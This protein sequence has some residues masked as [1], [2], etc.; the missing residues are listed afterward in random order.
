MVK[1]VYI[2]CSV[3]KYTQL[4]YLKVFTKRN[5]AIDF[6]KEKTKCG[7]FPPDVKTGYESYLGD[8]TVYFLKEKYV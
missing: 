3:N 5:E 8:E 2:V 6:W 1:E 7:N 4:R